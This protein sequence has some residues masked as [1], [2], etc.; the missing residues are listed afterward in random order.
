MIGAA[1][2]KK[3]L[4]SYRNP[5]DFIERDLIAGA[6]MAGDRFDARGVAAQ[7]VDERAHARWELLVN[8]SRHRIT[9]IVAMAGATPSGPRH[10]LRSGFGPDMSSGCRIDELSGE[11]QTV[12]PGANVSPM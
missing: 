12:A 6:V 10:F 1:R 2:Q 5:L 7:K 11:A 8:Y 3:T 4:V 9:L